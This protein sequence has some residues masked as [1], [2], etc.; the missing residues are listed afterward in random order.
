MTVDLE[1][2]PDPNDVRRHAK[3][4]HTEFGVPA[5]VPPHR[6]LPAERKQMPSGTT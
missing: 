3:R 4:M 6:F 5:Q 1:E 2:G